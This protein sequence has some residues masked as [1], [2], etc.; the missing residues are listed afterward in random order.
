MYI[1]TYIHQYTHATYTH[2][3][4]HLSIYEMSFLFTRAGAN[5]SIEDSMKWLPLHHA[6]DNNHKECVRIILS[7]QKGLT[8]LKLAQSLAGKNAR[9][10]ITQCICDAMSRY[11]ILLMYYKF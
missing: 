10:D 7:H 11:V 4:V 9:A 6:T 5:P 8:G 1:H 2:T 3:H